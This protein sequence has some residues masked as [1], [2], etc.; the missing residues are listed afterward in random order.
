[1]INRLLKNFDIFAHSFQ[2]NSSKQ[3]QRKRTCFGGFLSL[4]ITITTLI[5]FLYLNYQYFMN[6]FPPKFRSQSFVTNQ[7]ISISVHNEL[8]AFRFTSFYGNVT[9]DD[10]EAQSNKTYL[11]FTAVLAE[12]NSESMNFTQ[13]DITQCSNPQLNGYRCLDLSKL[14]IKY[15]INSNINK[16]LSYHNISIYRCQDT[17]YLKP[18]IPDNYVS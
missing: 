3:N 8:I 10:L 13:I 15:L 17:D 1:M 7:D 14:P 4:L 5:Y 18:T 11:V 12:I 9:L 2:F 6:Q 16:I